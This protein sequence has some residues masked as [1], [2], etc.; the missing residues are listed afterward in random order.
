M[1]NEIKLGINSSKLKKNKATS[2]SLSN[3]A[4]VESGSTRRNPNQIDNDK[5]DVT[6]VI[7]NVC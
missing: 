2:V 7:D 5:L 4:S 6:S 1:K 3:I